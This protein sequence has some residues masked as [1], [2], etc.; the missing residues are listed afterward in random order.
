MDKYLDYAMGHNLENR[1]PLWI[2]PD[3]KISVQD[4]MKF[5]RDHF[6][7]TQ[8]DMT[9]DIGAGPYHLPYRWRPLTWDVN[10]ETYFNERAVA[11][12]QTGFSFITESRNWLPD[13]IGGIFWFG[14]DDA[15]TT[16]Y[17]PMYC[18]ITK[19]PENFAVGNG[20]MLH[21][22][23][24]SAFWTF[25]F[26]SNFCYLRYDVMTQDVK[27]VQEELET[28]YIQNKQAIDKTAV[29]LYQENKENARRFIT[30][31]SVSIGKLT[32]DSWK[33]LGEFLLVKYIDGNIKKENNGV[34][35]TN[36]FSKTIPAY[37]QQPGYPKWWYDEIV[38]ETGDH[39]KVEGEGH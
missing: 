32:F 35:E 21:Y 18:G 33:K 13:W 37:P 30:D 31:Y 15:A 25:N 3:Y 16:V 5:M 24:E 39:F 11:T 22:S 29:E 12:Q 28:K 36:G 1:M 14:V 27:K 17:N 38:E 19:V 7:S 8:M 4:M 2:K 6:E 10:D 34:F 26:V 20:D 23:S 9:L